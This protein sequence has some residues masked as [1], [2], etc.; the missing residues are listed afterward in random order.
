MRA[1][2]ALATHFTVNEFVPRKAHPCDLCKLEMKNIEEI[3]GF[4]IL[5]VPHCGA[6]KPSTEL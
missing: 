1:P 3:I 2:H 6:P 5:K 4:I